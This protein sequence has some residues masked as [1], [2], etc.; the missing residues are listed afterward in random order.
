VTE[1]S[2]GSESPHLDDAQREQAADHSTPHSLV[3]HEIV[4]EE[5]ETAMER[6][7][8]AMASSSVAAGLSMGFWF[9]VEAIL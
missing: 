8:F 7:A 1:S 6:T 4:R 2:A 3:V 5:G 9:L